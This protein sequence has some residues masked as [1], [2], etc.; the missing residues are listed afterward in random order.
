MRER[1]LI[2]ERQLSRLESEKGLIEGAIQEINR[3]FAV[4]AEVEEWNLLT[5]PEDGADYP[6]TAQLESDGEEDVEGVR[7]DPVV[8]AA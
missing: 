7:A 2:L 8:L 6:E 3:R 1:R 4:L 5:E